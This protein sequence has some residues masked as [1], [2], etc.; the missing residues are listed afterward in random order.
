MQS[1]FRIPNQS[2]SDIRQTQITFTEVFYIVASFTILGNTKSQAKTDYI[3]FIWKQKN[4]VTFIY[5]VNKKSQYW[6]EA[7]QIIFALLDMTT[8]Y[9][10]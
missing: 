10:V 8:K 1:A 3:D 4:C 5:V 9:A 2:L 7:E 6:I